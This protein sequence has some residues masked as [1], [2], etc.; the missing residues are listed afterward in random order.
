MMV[1]R[2]LSNVY[3]EVQE[4]GEDIKNEQVLSYRWRYGSRSFLPLAN[5]W[6]TSVRNIIIGRF[7]ISNWLKIREIKIRLLYLENMLSSC[8]EIWIW[9]HHNFS[10]SKLETLIATFIIK[11]PP[12]W[13]GE[14]LSGETSQHKN[15]IAKCLIFLWEVQI[16]GAIIISQSSM[17]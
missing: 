1:P 3:R 6:W 2:I 11:L 16:S 7:E 15:W 8:Y 12:I 10:S 9:T 13:F 14:W 17:S 5:K 4:G